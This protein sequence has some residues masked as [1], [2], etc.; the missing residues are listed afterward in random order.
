MRKQSA[1][2]RKRRHRM[3]VQGALKRQKNGKKSSWTIRNCEKRNYSAWSER[4]H[5][6]GKLDAESWIAPST[7]GENNAR[8]AMSRISALATFQKREDLGFTSSPRGIIKE[9]AAVMNRE[10]DHQRF[11]DRLNLFQFNSSKYIRIGK[12]SVLC[13]NFSAMR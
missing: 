8:G 7:K 9:G 12:M 13:Q 4:D 5:K 6:Q 10:W 11:C 3:R 1:H 2:H